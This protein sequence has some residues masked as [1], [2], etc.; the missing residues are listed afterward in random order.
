MNNIYFQ[1]VEMFG[2]EVYQSKYYTS[3]LKGEGVEILKILNKY[4][5]WFEKDKVKPRDIIEQ[6]FLKTKHK[7]FSLVSV[8]KPNKSIV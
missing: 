6:V 8:K 7:L 2:A 4:Y 3:L 1:P 5:Y